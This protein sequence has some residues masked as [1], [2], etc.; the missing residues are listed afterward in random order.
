M[1][2]PE[3]LQ[4]SPN[5]VVAREKKYVGGAW[6]TLLGL[7]VTAILL[8]SGT[9]RVGQTLKE[10]QVTIRNQQE[11]IRTL[12]STADGNT[13][14]QR[15]VNDL[16]SQ[17]KTARDALGGQKDLVDK[18][19]A[20]EDARKRAEERVAQLEKQIGE[21]RS[22]NGKVALGIKCF[23]TLGGP[24]GSEAKADGFFQEADALV[25]KNPVTNALRGLKVEPVR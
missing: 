7:A 12:T 19:K 24:R 10:N 4:D 25:P 8:V 6:L 23:Y 22:A 18:L 3:R 2:E 20:A 16:E 5:E 17:L 11:T 15:R 14:L 9:S 1:I 21:Y 13:D